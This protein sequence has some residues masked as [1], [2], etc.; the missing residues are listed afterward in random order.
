MCCSVICI[1]NPRKCLR[2]VKGVARAGAFVTYIHRL[3]DGN[4]K[5]SWSVMQHARI[6]QFCQ[7]P[8]SAET[9]KERRLCSSYQRRICPPAGFDGMWMLSD[10][11]KLGKCVKFVRK[12]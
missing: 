6:S 2:M 11:S 8:V 7:K 3:R 1:F 5:C 4:E 9:G 12:K 10:I